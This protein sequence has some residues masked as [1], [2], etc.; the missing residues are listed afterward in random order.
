MGRVATFSA[1]PSRP[2]EPSIRTPRG[3]LASTVVKVAIPNG[4]RQPFDAVARRA[5]HPIPPVSVSSG[6]SSAR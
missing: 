4:H 6:G 2:S 5:C 3:V 1:D